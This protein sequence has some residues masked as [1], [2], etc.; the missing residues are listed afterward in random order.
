VVAVVFQLKQPAENF[1]DQFLLGDV[2]SHDQGLQV[3]VNGFLVYSG[4]AE[5]LDAGFQGGN[6]LGC[7]VLAHGIPPC[8]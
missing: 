2:A 6:D 1:L 7:A 8:G 4:Y 3:G 5:C